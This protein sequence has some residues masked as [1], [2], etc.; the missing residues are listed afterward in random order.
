MH[1][2]VCHV[3]VPQKPPR[4]ARKYLETKG[5]LVE[6]K[7]YRGDVGMKFGPWAKGVNCFGKGTLERSAGFWLLELEAALCGV[8]DGDGR[9]HDRLDARFPEG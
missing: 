9:L 8:V 7:E 4:E 2:A 6:L 3:S 5:N 1:N